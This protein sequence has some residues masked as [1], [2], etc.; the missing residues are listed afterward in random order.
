V[1]KTEDSTCTIGR[2]PPE[3]VAFTEFAL[4]DSFIGE[5]N[6]GGPGALGGPD[7]INRLREG[8]VEMIMMGVATSP[9]VGVGNTA[10]NALVTAFQ[11]PGQLAA[12]RALF[13]NYA[14]INPLKSTFSLVDGGNGF[15]A[16]GIPVT[17]ANFRTANAVTLQLPPTEIPPGFPVSY[18]DSW[19]E[20]SLYAANTIGARFRTDDT[21][22]N[23]CYNVA[24]PNSADP[25]SC[26]LLHTNVLNE[27]TRRTNPTAGWVTATDWVLTFPTKNMY[28]D[29]DPPNQWA[30]RNIGRGNAVLPPGPANPAPFFQMFV[31]TSVNPAIRRGWSC[32]SISVALYNR[33]EVKADRAGF[34]GGRSPEMCYQANTLTWENSNITRSQ[35]G[36][37]TIK[38]L[39]TFTNYPADFLFGWMNLNF[40]QAGAG[41]LPGVGFAITTR[42]DSASAL[43][44]EAALYDHG[45]VSPP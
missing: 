17:L 45:Y 41:G 36:S 30:G 3:G 42:D 9:T 19:H 16:V 44:S 4:P 40:A 1:L 37:G 15:N 33:A 22:T 28:V 27:W 32:D 26:A 25:V 29:N 35:T 31:D 14:G 20:P 38:G 39:Q 8:H 6:D 34:S 10:C 18:F 2:I 11:D 23:A 13:P 7:M 21:A 43:L 12:L 5:N 24:N